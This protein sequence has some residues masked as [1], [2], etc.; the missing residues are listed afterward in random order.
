MQERVGQVLGVADPLDA[1]LGCGGDLFEGV[2]GEVQP[3]P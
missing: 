3:Q 2:A 1:A